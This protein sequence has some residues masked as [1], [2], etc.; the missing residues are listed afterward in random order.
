M[1]EDGPKTL[2]R[3]SL[4]AAIRPVAEEAGRAALAFYGDKAEVREK[5]D[6]SPVTLADEAAEAVILPALRALTPTIP[7]VS[8]EEVALGLGPSH[9]G[10]R[11]WLVDPLDGTK[12]FLSGNGEFT[13]NIALIEDGRPVLGIV[14]AP[15]LGETYGGTDGQAYVIDAAG[16]RKILCRRPPAEGETV[17]GS[18]SHGDATAMDAFL[19]D[20]RVA[21][22]RAAGSSL[23]L[24]LIARGDADLYPRLGTTM[25]WDIAAGHAVLAAAGGRVTTVDGSVFVYG[26][27]DFRN[28]HFVAH[29]AGSA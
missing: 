22:F 4:L 21:A 3:A 16:E 28:P 29:G 25:E 12:E 2:C 13:V 1:R 24:C 14:V 5:A 7:V 18:R 10:A 6:G 20:R 9:V 23:K 15:A 8:E 11:F 26:K 27:P 19:K 17:V